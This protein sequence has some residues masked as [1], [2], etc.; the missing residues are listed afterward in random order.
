MHE[1]RV[2][3]PRPKGLSYIDS[4]DGGDRKRKSKRN[5][6]YRRDAMDRIPANTAA[7][8]FN[9]D[10]TGFGFSVLMPRSLMALSRTQRSILPSAKSSWSVASVIKRESTSKKSRNAARP[11]LR[12]KPSVP[13]EAS[14]RGIHL[15][16][17]LGS[18]FR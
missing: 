11:S 5:T 2:R 8:E 14:R 16:T 9:Q 7:P 10:M 6:K 15:L 18:V 17:I 12:P 13:S 4:N 1:S 3:I